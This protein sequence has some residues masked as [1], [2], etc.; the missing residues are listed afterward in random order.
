MVAKHSV[1][2]TSRASVGFFELVDQPVCTNQGF[3]SI[4]PFSETWTHF[5]L[6]QLSERVDEIRNMGAGSTYPEVSRG[7]FKEF[8]IV[9]PD[10]ETMSSF[11]Q[12][13]EPSIKQIWT[14]KRQNQKLRQARDLLL[15]KLMNG[16][17]EV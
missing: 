15:P 5:I 3:I 1:L 16:E 11:F 9:M 7:K 6:L 12:S 10:K 13:V 14:L 17:I 8:E 4:V 2:M